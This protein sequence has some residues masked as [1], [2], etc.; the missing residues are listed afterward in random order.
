MRVDPASRPPRSQHEAAPGQVVN[1]LRVAAE[2]SVDLGVR[3]VAA[4]SFKNIAKRNWVPDAGGG[5]PVCPPP[6]LSQ[7][8]ALRPCVQD[9]QQ[10]LQVP[11]DSSQTQLPGSCMAHCR[12][13][14]GV[15]A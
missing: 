15:G 6:P 13:A 10:Q 12:P 9:P 1:L 8:P 3:Q 11:P 7:H 2:P 4:I 5:P 14:A